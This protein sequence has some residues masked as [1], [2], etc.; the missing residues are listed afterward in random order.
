M[1]KN[2]PQIE[3]KR[4]SLIRMIYGENQG[5]SHKVVEALNKYNHKAMN[6]AL[7]TGRGGGG[8]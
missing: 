1:D 7:Q 4:D 3:E 2:D 8:H 5:R 6:P